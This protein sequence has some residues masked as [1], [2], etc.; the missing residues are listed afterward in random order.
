MVVKGSWT[1]LSTK[2]ST[3]GSRSMEKMRP[4]PCWDDISSLVEEDIRLSV[5]YCWVDMDSAMDVKEFWD[6]LSV[7][8]GGLG[9]V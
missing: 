4:R 1:T 9:S 6:G 5:W 2:S 3:A 7:G 8:G